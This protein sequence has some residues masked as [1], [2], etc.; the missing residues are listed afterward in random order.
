[1]LSNI[2]LNELKKVCYRY[3]EKDQNLISLKKEFNLSDDQI[4]LLFYTCVQKKLF[5][6]ELCNKIIEKH[7]NEVMVS[8]LN[9]ALVKSI[10]DRYTD[11]LHD[12]NHNSKGEHYDEIEQ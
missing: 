4:T 11:V 10:S 7:L 6:I 1:M 8:T 2:E 9:T 3:L 5:D 12:Y